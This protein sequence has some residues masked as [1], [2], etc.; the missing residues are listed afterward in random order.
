MQKKSNKPLI[1]FTTHH[2][3]IEKSLKKDETIK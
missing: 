1:N 2:G 3:Q